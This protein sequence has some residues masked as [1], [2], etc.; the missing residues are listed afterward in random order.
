MMQ[1]KNYKE[2]MFKIDKKPNNKKRLVPIPFLLQ[3][4]S[5]KQLFV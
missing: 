1:H 5:Y 4:D 2:F 3:L